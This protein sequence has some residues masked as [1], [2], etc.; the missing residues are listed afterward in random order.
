MLALTLATVYLHDISQIS[1]VEEFE[2]EVLEILI[3]Q[4]LEGVGHE[5][6]TLAE[7]CVEEN[8]EKRPTASQ[9]RGTGGI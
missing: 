1:Y 4:W 9:V 3:G 8:R 6:W 2:G 7:Q 5:A